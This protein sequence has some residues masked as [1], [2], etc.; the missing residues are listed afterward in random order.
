MVASV[1]GERLCLTTIVPSLP[2]LRWNCSI[3]LKGKSQIT[4]ELRT[5]NGSLSVLS[6]SRASARGP[7]AGRKKKGAG[8]LDASCH[9]GP[10][11]QCRR[12]YRRELTCSQRLLLVGQRN[13][14]PKLGRNQ[15]HVRLRDQC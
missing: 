8:K 15:R 6:N 11:L 9:K 5:K 10:I 2:W 7:A 14:N 12:C 3:S 4:S 13:A 1:S